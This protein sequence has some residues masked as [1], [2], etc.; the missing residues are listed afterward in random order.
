MSQLPL[1]FNHAPRFGAEDFLASPSNAE[2]LST[3]EAWPAWPD[4]VLMLIGPAG[5]GK[6]HLARIWAARAGALELQ[7]ADL[8]GDLPA[9]AQHPILIEDADREPVA[10]AALF[11]LLNLVRAG[12]GALVFAARTPPAQ[13]G[14][15]T[16]DLISRLR[17]APTVMLH[18]PDD[19]LLRAVVVKLFA[20]RQLAVDM[21]VVDY[22]SVRLDRS[23]A[24]ARDAVAALDRASLDRRRPITRMLAADVLGRVLD[25]GPL[26]DG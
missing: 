7:A 22:L 3:I 18:A 9:L 19:A 15:R 23:L 1:P 13:W 8:A 12:E 14:L 11:H 5:A 6:S 10:E 24:A 20:D 21:P 2:A 16:A 17:L 4:R 26:D 25:G